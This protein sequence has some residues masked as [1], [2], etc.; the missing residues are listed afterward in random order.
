MSFCTGFSSPTTHECQLGLWKASATWIESKVYD[1]GR[2]DDLD[3]IP[4]PD[5]IGETDAY[6]YYA[7]QLG[8]F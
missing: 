5:E 7:R 2:I 4:D 8:I 1:G 6:D 3:N